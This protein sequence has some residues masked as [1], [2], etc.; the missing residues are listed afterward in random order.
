MKK[1]SNLEISSLLIIITV[2]MCLGIN[3]NILQE[4]TDVNG[5]ISLVI[6]HVIGFIP[7]LIYLYIS[8]YKPTLPINEKINS[9]FGKYG[10][11][12][13]ILISIIFLIIGITLLC[14]LNNFIISQLLYRT[15]HIVIASPIIILAIYHISK[16]I[17]SIS[18]VS[19]IFLTI[20]IILSSIGFMSLFEKIELENFMP[21]LQTNTSS[22]I[23]SAIK[24]TCINSLPIIMLSCIPKENTYNPKKYN[25]CIII[26]Y[27]IGCIISLSIIIQTYGILGINLVKLF[28]YP[29][30]IVY[31]KIILLGFL[32][33]VENVISSQWIMG[34][35]IYI[36]LI[37]YFTSNN[38]KPK[39]IKNNT[40]LCVLIGLV[41][42]ISSITI[43]KNSTILHTYIKDI[44]PYICMTLILFYIIIPIKIFITKKRIK[45]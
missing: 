11:F 39:I 12:L 2:T 15:P 36:V 20:N 35:Y 16:G 19:L 1:I 8:S 3:I 7:L 25:K 22:I 41:I 30:Y 44:F 33:R 27:I 23:P 29:E 32:E 5:W 31:K 4:N 37:I 14:N 34:S 45:E 28:E 43:F 40:I 42:L 21:F 17:N 6:S 13:N 38:I 26:S 9:L 10:I 18:R 24:L